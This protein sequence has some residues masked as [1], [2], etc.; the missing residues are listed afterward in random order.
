MSDYIFLNPVKS[1][2]DMRG[3]ASPRFNR[4]LDFITIHFAHR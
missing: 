4:V 1:A 2:H 3:A